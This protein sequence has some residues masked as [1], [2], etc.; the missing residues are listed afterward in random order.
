MADFSKRL[1]DAMRELHLNQKQVAVMSG[2]SAASIS[3]Y[4]SGINTPS[5]S[6]KRD[7]ATALGLDAD[8]FSKDI[9]PIRATRHGR[10]SR[11]LPEQAARLLGVN[12]STVRK[13]LQ[14]GCFPWGYAIH[15]DSGKWVYIINADRFAEIEGVSVCP[16]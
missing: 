16:K 13:G 4:L 9:A 11:L 7:I 3:Q 14:Q 12:K 8:Y 15:M 1:E 10:I 2:C 5:D 6:K